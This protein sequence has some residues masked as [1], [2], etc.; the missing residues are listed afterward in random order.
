MGKIEE[1]KGVCLLSNE[2]VVLKMITMTYKTNLMGFNTYCCSNEK[3]C[4][5]ALRCNKS[6]RNQKSLTEA[7]NPTIK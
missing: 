1:K 2:I 3:E 6:S 7:L 4:E 5:F